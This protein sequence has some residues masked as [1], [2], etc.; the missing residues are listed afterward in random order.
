MTALSWDALVDR[1]YEAGVDHGVLYL[2]DNT[3]AYVNGYAWNGL[4]TVTESPDGAEASPQYAD[5][6]L[7][8]NLV[9]A[10]KFKGT[11]EAFTYPDEFSVCDGLATP[12][13]GVYV[14]QQP[15]RAFG[16]S[17]RTLIGNPIEGTELGYKLHLVYNALAT[18]SEKT[19]GTVNDSPEAVNFSWDITSTPIPVTGY[20]PTS[21]LTFDSTRV[22]ADALAAL[23]GFLYGTVGTDP[24]LP[25]PDEV[26]ALFSGTVTTTALP[27]APSYNS[28]TD[29][30][31][32]PTI[33]GVNYYDQDGTALVAGS[34]HTITENT[35]YTARPAPG[36]KFPAVSVNEWLIVFA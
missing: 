25:T 27:T 14:G 1:T 4:T 18:P 30:V 32:I 12:E 31:T 22:D 7:Y 24:S 19:H 23:E 11:I 17:Y 6:I 28:T 9:S 36:Y 34:T 13:N 3:G 35:V 16:F 29:V 21:V 2:A 33:T 20:K 10:E 15:R 8:L 26:I 5:N